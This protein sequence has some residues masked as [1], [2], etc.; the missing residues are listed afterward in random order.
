[1][2]RST[3]DHTKWIGA[4]HSKQDFIDLVEVLYRTALRGKFIAAQ[5]PID[6]K[7]IPKYTLIYND[8]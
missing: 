7:H 1:V 8:I 5:C 2:S 4:F 6:P 3:P